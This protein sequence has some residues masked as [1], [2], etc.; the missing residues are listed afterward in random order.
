MR[1]ISETPVNGVSLEKYLNVN[2]REV[3]GGE[4]GRPRD[5]FTQFFKFVL[6]LKCEFYSEHLAYMPQF[7]LKNLLR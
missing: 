7:D 6:Y 2:G 4:V 3:V 5:I 1:Q